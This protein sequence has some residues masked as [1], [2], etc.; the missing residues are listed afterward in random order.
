MPCHGQHATV[1]NIQRLLGYM[2]SVTAVTPYVR[3]H[4]RAL[5][6]WFI[7]ACH[8]WLH[9]QWSKLMIPRSI[10]RS[11]SWLGSHPNLC[12]GLPFG[13]PSI[14]CQIFTDAS[15]LGW[16][17]HCEPHRTQGVWSAAETKLHINL[18]EL[19]AIKMLFTLL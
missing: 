9:T 16:G 18:L 5:Q 14:D 15:L 4:M 13:V 17:E 19:R 8:P 2:A 11:L 6:N 10:L 12:A 3:L 7:R 1:W